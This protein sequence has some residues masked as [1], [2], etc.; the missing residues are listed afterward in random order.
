MQNIL[1]TNQ[2][3][4][5]HAHILQEEISIF[6]ATVLLQFGCKT[7]KFTCWIW[8]KDTRVS[9]GADKIT[10][11]LS[12]SNTIYNQYYIMGIHLKEKQQVMYTTLIQTCSYSSKIEKTV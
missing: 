6:R 2:G 3:L 11:G 4:Q 10:V 8:D 9:L 12:E 7:V 1:V 5:C